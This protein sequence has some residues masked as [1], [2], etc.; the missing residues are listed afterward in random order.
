MDVENPI[1]IPKL[2]TM[3]HTDTLQQGYEL[4]RK[5]YDALG[6]DTEMV[7]FGIW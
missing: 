2:I 1:F 6:V 7:L 5:Q 3:T 4:A